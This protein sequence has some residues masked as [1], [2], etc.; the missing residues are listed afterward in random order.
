MNKA[1]S[2]YMRQMQRRSAKVRWSGLSAAEKRQRMAALAKRR[3]AKRK[4][5]NARLEQQPTVLKGQ[6]GRRK[7]EPR[8]P[9]HIPNQEC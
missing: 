7:T 2:D 8:R 5:A 1:V 6:T 3:W 9:K 4:P